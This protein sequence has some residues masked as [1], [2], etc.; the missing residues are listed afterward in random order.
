[1][2]ADDEAVVNNLRLIMQQLHQQ[3]PQARIVMYSILP[4]R[5]TYIPSTRIRQVNQQ[6]AATAAQQ[7][8]DYVD[9]QSEF[10][11]AQG[12][13]NRALTTDGLHLNLQG[14]QVWHSAMLG[15]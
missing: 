4:T 11:D 14:Y 5:L 9:L 1:Q 7:G 8:V 13:L 10:V 3:H 15:I 2:G 12:N 6:I